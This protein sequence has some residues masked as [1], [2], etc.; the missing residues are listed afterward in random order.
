[1]LHRISI[2]LPA[3]FSITAWCIVD[4]W[5]RS[6]I[7]VFLKFWSLAKFIACPKLGQ[8]KMQMAEHPRVLT[9]S[10]KEISVIAV[11]RNIGV[12]REAIFQLKGFGWVIAIR[13]DM[14]EEVGLWRTKVDLTKNG[15]AFKAWNN[16]IS[17][18]NFVWI[19][20]TSTMSFST[21]CQP[22]LF[23]STPEGSLSTM[24]PCSNE[25]EKA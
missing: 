3:S 24:T 15:Q 18:Y 25:K 8:K 9:L 10:Q 4:W 5:N 12:S 2:V 7:F 6:K 13:D 21:T 23:V 22:R 20:K 17:V 16:I 11:A 19:K 1:M 14:E